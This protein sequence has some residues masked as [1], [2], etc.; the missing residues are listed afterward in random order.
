MASMMPLRSSPLLPSSSSR[1]TEICSTM[2]SAMITAPS[3]MIPKSRAPR[4]IRLASIPNIN[5]MEMVKSSASGMMEV[6]TSAERIL[7][8]RSSTVSM[9]MSAPSTRFSTTVREVFATSSLLSTMGLIV[10]PSGRLC[11][12]SSTRFLTSLITSRES[13]SLSI[14]T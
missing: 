8:S 13:A 10:I 1:R 3:M 11:P 2:N 14:I 6:I 4:L 7:P 5:I 12:I 9:T